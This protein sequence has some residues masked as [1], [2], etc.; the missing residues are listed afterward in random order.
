[1][2]KPPEGHLF[3]W[4]T[5]QAR[6]WREMMRQT[7]KALAAKGTVLN[8]DNIKELLGP[9]W[10]WRA[11]RLFQAVCFRLGDWQDAELR[12][13]IDQHNEDVRRRWQERGCH[14]LRKYREVAELKLHHFGPEPRGQKPVKR[15]ATEKE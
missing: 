7:V 6:G 12:K 14:P 4:N 15:T 2:E 9:K 13:V 1:L 11:A 3:G 10:A 8:E 5:P